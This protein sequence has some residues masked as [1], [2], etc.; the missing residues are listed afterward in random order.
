MPKVRILNFLCAV[1]LATLFLLSANAQKDVAER[2]A[3]VG[4]V[5]GFPSLANPDSTALL[6]KS[7]RVGLYLHAEAWRPLDADTQ[8]T[9]L[10]VFENTGPS[11]VEL[12]FNATSK[13]YFKNFYKVGFI[14]RGVFAE[15][16]LVNGLSKAEKD[17]AHD[18]IDNARLYGLKRVAP[19]FSPNSGQFKT[20]SFSDA[21]WN[22]LRETA[23][24]GG[25][26][27][28]DSPPH[29]FLALGQKYQQFV[30]DE[31]TWARSQHIPVYAIISA[32]A[33]KERFFKES[34]SM[35]GVLRRNNA[36]PSHY[37]LET[38]DL[39]FLDSPNTVGGES[40]K[41][42]LLNV[43]LELLQHHWLGQ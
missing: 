43:A 19:V 20:S 13:G 40:E 1:M 22:N 37:V 24:Y 35:L 34:R 32:N 3:T 4:G 33:S 12:G 6:R 42:T 5:K 38:Y 36:P 7:G 26:L 15:T 30:I 2:Q 8:K 25:A 17:Q 28:I 41:G 29:V 23:L 11:V 10:K 27:A 14:D 39:K 21:R 16:A 9:I 18:Y 31:I